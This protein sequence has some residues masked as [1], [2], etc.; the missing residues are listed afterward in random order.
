M[1][2]HSKFAIC[3]VGF[4]AMCSASWR[5]IV[6]MILSA[7]RPQPERACAWI[8]ATVLETST[9][10]QAPMIAA[11]SLASVFVISMA[12]PLARSSIE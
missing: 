1:S 9:P 12:R 6:S 11:K 3:A 2:R 5:K 4:T 7:W 8:L 10:L